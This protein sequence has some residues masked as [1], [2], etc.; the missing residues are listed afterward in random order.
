MQ[1]EGS[2]SLHPQQTGIRRAFLGRDRL[3]RSNRRY[4]REVVER[5][6]VLDETQG[7]NG[8]E[9][10]WNRILPLALD[11][12]V[13]KQRR[14]QFL[15]FFVYDAP[16]RFPIDTLGQPL[17]ALRYSCRSDPTMRSAS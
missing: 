5:A 11:V 9:S 17:A 7:D 4:H 14:K 6:I 16:D 12:G 2:R 8:H 13:G 15:G 3:R 1:R 10:Q